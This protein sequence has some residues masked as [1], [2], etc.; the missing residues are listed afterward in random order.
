MQTLLLTTCPVLFNLMISKAYE[1]AD[2]EFIEFSLEDVLTSAEQSVDSTLLL[3]M[4]RVEADAVP[5]DQAVVV[6]G[7][8]DASSIIQKLKYMSL[9]IDKSIP[10]VQPEYSWT[11]N[12]R[13]VQKCIDDTIS[14]LSSIIFEIGCSMYFDFALFPAKQ[15]STATK[16]ADK[17]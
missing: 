17:T 3:I 12:T 8:V 13:I 10:S 16:T 7:D 6:S 5:A 1:K 4:K 15:C 2:F 11:G 14:G 9:M